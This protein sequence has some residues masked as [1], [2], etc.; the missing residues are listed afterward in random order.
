MKRPIDRRSFLKITSGAAAAAAGWTGPAQAQAPTKVNVGYLHVVTVDAQLMLGQELGTYKKEG[1]DLQ[2]REFTTGVELFQA[3]V[4]GSLDVLTTGGV[5]SNFPARGQGKVFLIN[6]LEWAVGQIWVYPDQ[7]IT[8]IKDL[9]GK[10]IATTRG[11]TAHDLLHQALKSVNLDST[12]DVEIVNQRMS[13][14]VTSFIAGAVPAVALWVPFNVSVKAKAPKAKMLTDA[15]AFPAATIVDGWAARNDYYEKNR[16]A[17]IKLIRGWIPANEFLLTKTGEA[18]EILHKKYYQ[19]QNFSMD[20][21]REMYNAARWY[22][23]AEWLKYYQD[24]SVVKWLNQVTNFNVEVGAIQNPVMA[25]KYFDPK[26]F[27]EVA[28]SL[29]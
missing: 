2:L 16:E 18:L 9:K 26:P 19:N 1:L 15:G 29:R 10:K 5:L 12:K 6:D 25:D 14:A 22:K 21:M 27:V 8:S 28:S 13:E 11:T 17:L 20:D 4:G 7:G 24:G 3:L 23:T